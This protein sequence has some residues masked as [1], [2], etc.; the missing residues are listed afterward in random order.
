MAE[1]RKLVI[2][3][4]AIN[5][6]PTKNQNSESDDENNDS[7]N[8]TRRF[9]WEDHSTGTAR[10][11]INKMGYKGKGLGKREDGIE[12]AITV[13][14]FTPELQEK[15]IDT[16]VFS[17]S[18]T[19]GINTNGFNKLY[20]GKTAKLHKFHGR[21]ASQIKEYMPVNLQK[22]KPRSVVIVA[23]GNSVPTESRCSLQKLEKIVE[24]VISSG[25]LCKDYGVQRVL[26]SS[27]LPRQSAYYQSRRYK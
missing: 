13:E 16:L 14:D 11:V 26:I 23:S 18:I 10:N 6:T 20:Q 12:D 17:S 3:G 15:S 21:N 27:F 7:S 9:E 1:L 24:D 22:D 4:N 2:E 25:T 19:K 8:S 5:S